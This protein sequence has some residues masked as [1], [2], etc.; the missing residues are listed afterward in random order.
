MEDLPSHGRQFGRLA[1]WLAR[2]LDTE[3]VTG[4]IPVSPTQ[5]ADERAHHGGACAGVERAGV[6]DLRGRHFL[7][8]ADFTRDELQ[9][10]IDLAATLKAERQ[11]GRERPRLSGKAIALLFEKASTRTRCAFE[12]AAYH[13]GAHVTVLDPSSSHIG[14]KESAADTARVLSRMYDGIEFRG[15]A[16]ATVEDLA[17]NSRVPVY[18]GLTDEWHP[19][20][21]LADFL[22]M[23][24]H[25]G[26]RGFADIAYTYVGDARNNMGNS[27]LVM[28]AI[29]GADVRICAPESLWPAPE[30]RR[31][32]EERAAQSGARLLLTADPREALPGS[33]FVATDVW[34]SMGEAP[35]VW[36]ER[37]ALLRDYRVDADLMALTGRPDV[38]FLHCL[39]AFH[40]ASTEVG[41]RIAAESGLGDGIEVSDEVF[42]SAASVAF[43]EAENRLHTIKAVLVATLADG[44]S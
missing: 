11:A 41:R 34:V 2:F 8:E 33:D 27:L 7:R 42:E 5:S 44:A 20:Q 18:N 19:T 26:G 40:D 25:A 22:T 9:Y 39:P 24:E 35:E 17:R 6:V 32:A 12:V 10:L 36:A 29:M 38:R 14:V 4:S 28:G 16:Q 13:Q 43:D 30:A 1:Q 21:M 3:E 37:I 15:R 31:I 23:A